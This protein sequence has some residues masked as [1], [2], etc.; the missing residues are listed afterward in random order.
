M[1]IIFYRPA[2]MFVDGQRY[3]Y[4]PPVIST[5]PPVAEQGLEGSAWLST[6]PPASNLINTALR[7]GVDG[8]PSVLVH[9]Y[10]YGT[11][12]TYHFQSIHAYRGH[13]SPSTSTAAGTASPSPCCIT[14]R[15]A[16]WC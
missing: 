6:F 13:G 15:C 11:Q 16:T 10:T 12:Q 7:L 8:N 4:R 3:F 14:T 5:P 1:L 2:S 9:V